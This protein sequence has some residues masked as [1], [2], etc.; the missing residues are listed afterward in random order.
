MHAPLQHK[1]LRSRKISWI[2]SDIKKLI[3]TRDKLKRKAILTNLE[4]DWLNYKTSRKKVNIEL[5][6]AKKD[7]YSS[8]IAGQKFDPKR[9]WKSINNILGRQNKPTVVD[10]LNLDQNN[11]TSPEDIAEGFNDYFS[12]IGPD[13]ASK[14]DSSN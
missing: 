3:Y 8:K 5:R 14:I 2:T 12:N 10:E 13:L 6:N 7:Y 1:K 9:A 4:N 11:L